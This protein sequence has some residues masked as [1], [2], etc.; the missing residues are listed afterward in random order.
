MSD[1]HVGNPKY[2]IPL[3]FM[4]LDSFIL[5]QCSL[6]EHPQNN[7]RSQYMLQKHEYYLYVKYA[8]LVSDSNYIPVYRGEQECMYIGMRHIT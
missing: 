4:V 1:S 2:R 7:A 8:I 6:A 3:A 5:I